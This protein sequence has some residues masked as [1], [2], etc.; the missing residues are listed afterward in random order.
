M[1]H[2]QPHHLSDDSW[3]RREAI[4]LRFEAAWREQ[5]EPVIEDFSS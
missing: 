1:I 3:M 2:E 4:L 5:S